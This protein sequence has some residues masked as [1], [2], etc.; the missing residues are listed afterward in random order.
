VA[1]RGLLWR[2]LRRILT[3]GELNVC[4]SVIWH[5]GFS[6]LR[7]VALKWCRGASCGARYCL[8]DR[9][10]LL[11]GLL[12]QTLTFGVLSVCRSVIWR[13]GRSHLLLVALGGPLGRLAA[14]G[15]TEWL[16]G[17]YYDVLS[18]KLQV[19]DRSVAFY[20]GES[21]GAL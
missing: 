6:H 12:G 15:F 4:R 1:R 9:R 20:G 14:P 11:R 5:I 21:S 13:I 18:A 19:Y 16:V 17:V 3:P 2:L 8:V 10:G 7:P